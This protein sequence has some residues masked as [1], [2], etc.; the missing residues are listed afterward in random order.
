[1]T[2][3]RTRTL[4]PWTITRHQCPAMLLPPL[5]THTANCNGYYRIQNIRYIIVINYM[6]VTRRL[7]WRF[8]AVAVALFFLFSRHCS[9]RHWFCFLCA[10][11]PM[12]PAVVFWASRTYCLLRTIWMPFDPSGSPV[13]SLNLVRYHHLLPASSM[14]YLC[15]HHSDCSIFPFISVMLSMLVAIIH[16]IQNRNPKILSFERNSP[17]SSPRSS[18]NTEEIARIRSE[19]SDLRIRAKSYRANIVNDND[20]NDGPTENHLLWFCV[21]FDNMGCRRMIP[22]AWMIL[23]HP[24]DNERGSTSVVCPNVE[25]PVDTIKIRHS[26]GVIHTHGNRK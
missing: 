7:C 19:Y 8:S 10:P 5:H 3:K 4:I 13:L 2:I 20:I 18:K 22:W 11:R 15:D 23:E 24:R 14:T 26:H 12:H 25:A 6:Y 9:C 21:L 16:S 17:H 1:M